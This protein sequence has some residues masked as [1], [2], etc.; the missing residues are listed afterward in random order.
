M[1][2][3]NT[4]KKTELVKKKKDPLCSAQQNWRP[5]NKMNITAVASLSVRRFCLGC[6]LEIQTLKN[7]SKSAEPNSLIFLLIICWTSTTSATLIWKL[8]VLN[9]SR[10]EN[11]ASLAFASINN[12]ENYTTFITRH[13][14][15]RTNSLNTWKRVWVWM[16]HSSKPVQK[17]IY[18]Y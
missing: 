4:L 11:R 14:N 17:V 7:I 10:N 6:R 18:G 3:I 1:Q 12:L 16:F 15:K 8:D 9:K 2:A 13:K 5:L